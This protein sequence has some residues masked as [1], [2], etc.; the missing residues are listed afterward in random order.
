ML[1][2]LISGLMV[3]FFHVYMKKSSNRFLKRKGLQIY[4]SSIKTKRGD[5]GGV[6]ELSIEVNVILEML[7]L[8]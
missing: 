4:L 8:N 1:K 2:Y 3:Q 7:F 5:R 6:K